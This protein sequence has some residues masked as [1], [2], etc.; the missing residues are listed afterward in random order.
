MQY[1]QNSSAFLWFF[2]NKLQ[3]IV[4]IAHHYR[5]YFVHRTIVNALSSCYNRLES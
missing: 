1:Q 2:F 4:Q 5:R 3:L